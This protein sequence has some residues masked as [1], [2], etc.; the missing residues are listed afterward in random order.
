MDKLELFT[1][2]FKS[3][4]AIGVEFNEGLLSITTKE[5]L[6]NEIGNDM[7]EL[8]PIVAKMMKFINKKAN[9]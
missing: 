7:N 3:N 2:S 9:K 8:K 5:E 4:G 1:V 6:F